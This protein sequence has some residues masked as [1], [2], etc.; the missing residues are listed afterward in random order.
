MLPSVLLI[1]LYHLIMPCLVNDRIG[2]VT[3]IDNNCRSAS[4]T[5]C[6][7]FEL[8]SLYLITELIF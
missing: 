5:V 7:V 4:L 8:I 6:A 2:S 1:Y 3:L